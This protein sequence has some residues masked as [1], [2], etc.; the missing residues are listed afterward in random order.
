MCL[1]GHKMRAHRVENISSTYPM[2]FNSSR[3]APSLRHVGQ[4]IYLYMAVGGL[5]CS[6][7]VLGCNLVASASPWHELCTHRTHV[8][9]WEPRFVGLTREHGYPIFTHAHVCEIVATNDDIGFLGDNI[10]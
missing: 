10:L 8:H 4:G 7:S 3:S 5:W 2:A 9:T 1:D 6:W